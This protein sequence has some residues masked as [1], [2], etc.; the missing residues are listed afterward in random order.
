[1]DLEEDES[2]AQLAD[3]GGAAAAAAGMDVDGGPLAGPGEPEE[4]PDDP[5]YTAVL[6]AFPAL[7]PAYHN[8]LTLEQ[9]E[10][11]QMHAAKCPKDSRLHFLAELREFLL[12]CPSSAEYR[13]GNAQTPDR[14]LK[15][16]LDT[17]I[18]TKNEEN[19]IEDDSDDDA[20]EGDLPDMQWLSEDDVPGQQSITMS[21]A[22]AVW[23]L[24]A[25][26]DLFA[27]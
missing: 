3:G 19:G 4:V 5:I 24:V 12:V 7:V 14:D 11:I 10:Y 15:S 1:M 16:F 13:E 9:K 8:R 2:L 18:D 26:V 6:V 27:V 21:L 20:E 25:A 22:P 17:V 23:A